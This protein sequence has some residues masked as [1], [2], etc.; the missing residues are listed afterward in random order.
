[1]S[2][3]QGLPA[4]KPVEGLRT[5][6][7]ENQMPHSV[8]TSMYL[9]RLSLLRGPKVRSELPALAAKLRAFSSLL[10]LPSRAQSVIKALRR[11]GIG[12]AD[13]VNTARFSSPDLKAFPLLK[14]S[15][16]SSAGGQ[17]LVAFP[18]CAQLLRTATHLFPA[19]APKRRDC[20]I[21]SVP[22]PLHSINPTDSPD[23][24]ISVG[25]LVVLSVSLYLSR[26]DRYLPLQP[27][28]VRLLPRPTGLLL[29]HLPSVS[30]SASRKRKPPS[31]TTGQ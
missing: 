11:Q 26:K 14:K 2:P 27:S 31:N 24:R 29:W 21:Y 30:A 6:G 3:S 4:S 28:S 8:G 9:I 17:G 25:A 18:V 20:V 16:K 13:V 12:F 7:G 5:F 19:H 22:H 1:M 23:S 10:S 15:F